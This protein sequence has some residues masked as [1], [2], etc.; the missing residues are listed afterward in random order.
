MQIIGI[1]I[2]HCRSS[3]NRVHCKLKTIKKSSPWRSQLSFEGKPGLTHGQEDG[4]RTL[5]KENGSS[6]SC[7]SEKCRTLPP[8]EMMGDEAEKE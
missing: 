4:N 3:E 6:Q 7:G 2:K 5:D 1:C 8:A